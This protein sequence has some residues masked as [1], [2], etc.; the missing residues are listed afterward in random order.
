MMHAPPCLYVCAAY[1]IGLPIRQLLYHP[2]ESPDP[3][4]A[5][6]LAKRKAGGRT[7]AMR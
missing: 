7:L 1:S 5:E 4:V 3:R 6:A 2:L